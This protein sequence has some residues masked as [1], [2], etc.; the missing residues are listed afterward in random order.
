M[1][2]IRRINENLEHLSAMLN[3]YSAKLRDDVSNFSLRI[4]IDNLNRQI[5]ELQ[6]QLY[7]ENILR[8]KEIIQLRFIGKAARFGTF[9]LHLVGGL[10]DSFSKAI[11]NSSKFR[12]FGRKGGK[13]IEE[14]V[15]NTIDLKLEGIGKGSTIFYLSASTT[16]DLFGYSII[17]STFDSVFSLL[18]SETHED[19]I[20]NI[21]LVGTGSI[22]YF[23]NFFGELNRDELELEMK[24]YTPNER[25]E[26]WNGTKNKIQVIFN[27]LN[28]IKLS[29]PEEI[30]FIGEIITLSS[31]GK[32]EV[33]TIQNERFFGTFPNALIEE[34]KQLHI[35]QICNCVLSKTTIFNPA[36][37]KEKFEY[38]LKSISPV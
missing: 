13:R 27:T 32:F 26:Q 1:A 14:I 30:N 35:G 29:E 16:P 23:S 37:G 20:D 9:P 28:S 17:Q 24:W 11:F 31:K 10:T 21:S 7:N 6:Q 18:N 2:S 12:Q 3:E 19:L 5:E 36:T 8:E 4:T 33:V 34:V 38:L 25:V 22:K 15:K